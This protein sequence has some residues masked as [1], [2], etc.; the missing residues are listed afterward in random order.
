[1]TGYQ[2]YMMYLALRNHFNSDSYDYFKYNKKV[3]AAET[4]FRRR[5]DRWHFEKIARKYEGESEN[6][7]IANLLE[8][9]QFWVGNAMKPDCHEK[10]TN[11]VK[12]YEG[13]EYTLRQDLLRIFE[14]IEENQ[15]LTF[16]RVLQVPK[17][18]RH[19]VL[20]KMFMKEEISLETF[21]ILMN[22]YALD[23]LYNEKYSNDPIWKNIRNK[24][25]KYLPFLMQQ[26]SESGY[27][28][29]IQTVLRS[30]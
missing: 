22:H 26:K 17:D 14:V 24:A 30:V 2:V 7:L 23:E 25:Q 5:R 21:T 11:W 16:L 12:R 20:M 4:T 1:M 27:E 10:Y 8:D 6:F 18:G 15:N 3:N 19:S 29:C 13:V 9:P 28:E